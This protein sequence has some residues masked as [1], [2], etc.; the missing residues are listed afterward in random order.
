VNVE[1]LDG[2][3]DGAELAVL[4]HKGRMPPMAPAPPMVSFTAILTVGSL[5]GYVYW[6]DEQD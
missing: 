5:G 6:Q 1:R 3:D 4:A 2:Q